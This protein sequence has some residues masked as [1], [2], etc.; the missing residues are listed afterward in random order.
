MDL[1]LTRN[2]LNYFISRN[3]KQNTSVRLQSA[4][5]LLRILNCGTALRI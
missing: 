1:S 5:S 2:H 3:R 4:A